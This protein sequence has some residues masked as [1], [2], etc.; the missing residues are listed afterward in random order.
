MHAID[1][2]WK[3]RRKETVKMCECCRNHEHP[4]HAPFKQC[5]R[6]VKAVNRRV[7][8]CSS[9]CQ[10]KDWPVHKRICGKDLSLETAKNTAIPPT[11]T[12]GNGDKPE[13]GPPIK[14]FKRSQA[15]TAQ[16]QTLNN[17]P[18]IDYVLLSSKG[19]AHNLVI[20]TAIKFKFRE[21]R[22]DAFTTGKR[23]SASYIAQ[24]LVREASRILGNTTAV[25]SAS[26]I[27]AQLKREFEFDVAT[28]V[29]AIEVALSRDPRTRGRTQL[30]VDNEEML[31]AT[32]SDPDSA[33]Q[34][35]ALLKESL[36]NS[37]MLEFAEMIARSPAGASGDPKMEAARR[38]FNDLIGDG[39]ISH[40]MDNLKKLGLGE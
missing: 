30:E 15:L 8:Y 20:P 37:G 5:S 34:T 25:P 2:E 33:A 27:V 21:L 18:Q 10:T 17:S 1:Q 26:D 36:R 35:K 32:T 39:D 29:D 22:N 24:Y 7:F 31:R 12:N 9:E 40:A 28:A 19:I 23:K 6:C 3:D 13:I 14:G 4:N 16:I 38:A 11:P